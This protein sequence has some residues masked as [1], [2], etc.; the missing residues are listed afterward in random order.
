VLNHIKKIHLPYTVIDVGWWYQGTLPKLPSGRIDYLV[1]FP[2]EH[3][4]GDGQIPSALTDLRD[5]GKYVARI[6]ADTRT[7]N[8]YVFVYNEVLTQEQIWSELEQASGEQLTRTYKSREETEK[9]IELAR[10]EL[11]KNPNSALAFITLTIHEYNYTVWIRRD[12]T[13]DN[14]D[15]LGYLNGKELYPDVSFIK[16]KDYVREAVEGNGQPTYVNR[17]FAFE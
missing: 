12:N 13:P 16:Y 2:I 3:L 8:R 4:N 15:Y 7:L 11:D 9:A 17:K 14:A 5:I 1:K 10:P 6:I